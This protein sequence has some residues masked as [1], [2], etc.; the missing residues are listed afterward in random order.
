MALIIAKFGGSVLS[1]ARGYLEAARLVEKL[2]SE[3]HQ[4]V[5]V[6]SAM[7]GVTDTLLSF[8]RL[9]AEKTAKSVYERYATTLKSLGLP[10]DLHARAASELAIASNSLFKALWAVGVL[11]E[12]TPRARDYI[13]SFGEKLSAIVMSAALQARGLRARW[14]TGREAGIVTDDRFGEANPIHEVSAKLVRETLKPLLDE[15]VVPVVTGFIAGTVDGTVTLLGRGGS[16]Y[17]A[18]LIASY[19][20][21]DE[22]RLYTDVPG[23]M[24]GDPRRIPS[25]RSLKLLSY[26]EAS[27][28]ARLGLRKFHPRT[29]E[30]LEGQDIPVRVLDLAH[31]GTTTI[32][33]NGGPPPVKAVTVLEELAVVT[34]RGPGLAGRVGVLARAASLLAGSGV[35][36]VSVTQPPSETSI[37][38]IVNASDAEK[39]RRSLARLVR[40]GVAVAVEVYA[41][42]AAVS[43]VG[44]GV[45]EPETISRIHGI[46]LQY[47]TKT[48]VWSYTSPVVSA[49]VDKSEAWQLA[50]RLHDEVVAP[51][52]AG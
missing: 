3:G 29:F 18:T 7:K 10:Q 49:I 52:L 35:N 42:V 20:A 24:S 9:G 8:Q 38:F 25:A 48:M 16:D 4:V 2:V 5:V 6:V 36:I 46:A 1:S 37:S 44:V 51:W 14:L 19:L 13:A 34:L 47:H 22:V 11:G 39:A 26:R 33:R 30:P 43:V 45:L 21:A 15:G 50:R 17:T 40:E 23:I 27:E 31:R 32:T 41:P 28:L 12:A